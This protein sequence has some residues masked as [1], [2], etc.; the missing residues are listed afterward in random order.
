MGKAADDK[1]VCVGMVGAPHGVRGEVR[2]KSET[3]DPLAI[4]A[5]GPLTT[6]D[7]RTVEILKARIAKDMVIA[8]LKGVNDRDAAEALKNRRLYVGRDRLPEPDEDE[9]YYADLIGLEVRD[10][11]G[12]TVGTVTAVQD[13]G[14]G[15]L[16]EVRLAGGKRTVFVPFTREIVPVVDIAAGH[17]VIEAPDG[18]LSQEPPEEEGGEDGR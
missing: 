5:Y 2:I 17:V 6:E 18:L 1:R 4:A 7:G 8:A 10:G 14:G 13:F 11:A 3:E 16:L 9:W 15:D 12:E